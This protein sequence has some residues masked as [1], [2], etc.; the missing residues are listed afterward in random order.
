MAHWPLP[1]DCPVLQFWKMFF[2]LEKIISLVMLYYEYTDTRMYTV[3]YFCVFLY[4]IFIGLFRVCY[5]S[6]YLGVTC[7]KMHEI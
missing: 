2:C 4:F 3:L 1:S 6:G 7:T 5:L